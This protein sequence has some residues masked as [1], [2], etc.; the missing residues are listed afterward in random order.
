MKKGKSANDINYY[1][2]PWNLINVYGSLEGG[3]SWRPKLN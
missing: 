1:Y 2:P 3:G